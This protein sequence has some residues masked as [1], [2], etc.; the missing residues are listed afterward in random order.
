MFESHNKNLYIWVTNFEFMITQRD[1][2]STLQWSENIF[3]N[4]I[5]NNQ[6]LKIINWVI[7]LITM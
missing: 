2:P 3:R 6:W 5:E 4:Q 1:K 7:E